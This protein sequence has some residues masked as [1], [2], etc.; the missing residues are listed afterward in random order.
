[1][2]SH[3]DLQLYCQKLIRH[4]DWEN[5]MLS[6]SIGKQN[7]VHHFFTGPGTQC[8]FVFTTISSGLTNSQPVLLQLAQLFL[9]DSW[10]WLQ[11]SSWVALNFCFSCRGQ[12]PT[13]QSHQVPSRSISYAHLKPWMPSASRSPM[14]QFDQPTDT[15]MKPLNFVLRPRR[16]RQL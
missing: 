6:Q 5:I 15:D 12:D 10:E 3:M 16:E 4:Q 14:E 11:G 1:M 9:R 2:R 8:L 7:I 13:V